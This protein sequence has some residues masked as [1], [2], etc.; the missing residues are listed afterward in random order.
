MFS[1]FWP[2][3]ADLSLVQ[4]GNAGE[5]FDKIKAGELTLHVSA[6]I[7]IKLCNR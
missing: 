5:I 3:F 2:S 1:R 6:R 4:Q 7:A